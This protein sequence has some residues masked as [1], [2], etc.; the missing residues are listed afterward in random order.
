[1]M[2]MIA[3]F[4]IA[5]AF[6][7]EQGGVRKSVVMQTPEW[8]QLTSLV[9]EWDAVVDANGN[10]VTTALEIR[11]TGDGST[12]MHWMDKGST[13]EMVT[14]IHPD[15]KRILATHYCS[16]HNQPR[17]AMVPAKAPNQIAFEFVDGTNISPG[18]GYM[19]AVVFTFFSA[20]QHEEVWTHSSSAIPA[21]FKYKRKKN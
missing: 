2:A 1:M 3:I 7:Q 12:I 20:D 4:A 6:A 17:M 15:G 16:A 11:M 18:D 13:H 14:M 19:K 9:G 8:K 10:S 21:V 5:H